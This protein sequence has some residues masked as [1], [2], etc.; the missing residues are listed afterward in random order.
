MSCRTTCPTLRTK[1]GS[2][3][4][5]KNLRQEAEKREGGAGGKREGSG[6]KS[7]RGV[8]SY[9]AAA[10]VAAV[11]IG[12]RGTFTR[13]A[14][15]ASQCALIGELKAGWGAMQREVQQ[16]AA[17]EITKESKA[18]LVR[19]L[20][21]ANA[22]IAVLESEAAAAHPASRPTPNPVTASNPRLRGPTPT[23]APTPAPEPKQRKYNSYVT[24]MR[25]VKKLR[26]FLGLY[27]PEAHAD[28]VARAIVVDGRGKKS[29]ISV[30][31]VRDLFAN[32]RMAVHMKA[33]AEDILTRAK[34]HMQTA[35]FSAANFTSARRLCRLSYRKLGWLRR[36]LSHNGKTSRL[37]LPPYS[38]CVPMMPSVPAMKY[39]EQSMLDAHGGIVQQEDGRGA[40]CEDLERVLCSAI[41]YAHTR[42]V[43]ASDGSEADPHIFMWGGDGFMARKKSKWVQ[44]GVILCSTTSLNQSPVDSKFVLNYA[45]GEDYDVLSIRTEDLRPVL[46]R[47]AREGKVWD[48]Y[49]KLPSGIGAHVQ[50]AL[51]GDKP[52]ILT[53]LGRRNMNHTHFSA[54]C[55]CTRE[56]ISCLDCE[57]GQE[58]HYVTDPDEMCRASH[59]CP[60]MWLRGG[61]FVPFKCPCCPAEFTCVSDVEAEEARV[62]VMDACTFHRWAD[63]FSHAHWGRDWNAGVLLPFKWIWSDPLHLFLNL[64]NVAFDEGVDFFLQHEH[65][66][67][68]SKELIAECHTISVA[69]NRELAGAHIT[70]RFGTDERKSFCGNDLRALMQHPYVLPEIM[71]LVRPLYLRMEPCSFAAD[72][73]KARK[74]KKRIEE[75]LEKEQE[76]GIKGGGGRAR[77]V[78]ADSFNETA[79]ISA[80]AARRVRKTQAALQVATEKTLTF[81]DRF[82]SHIDAMS[83]AIDGNYNWCVI[84]ML[85]ALVEFYEWVHAKSWLADALAADAEL[86]GGEG[87]R[88]GR[89]PSVTET[90]KRRRTECMERS[91]ALAK[92]IIAAVGVARKQTYV[93]D[94]VY[95]LHRVFD[96]VLHLLLAGMQGVEHVNKQMKL[97]LVSQCTAANNNRKTA[98]GKQMLGDVAQAA[99]C[100]VARQHIVE[101]R[102]DSLP[103]SQYGQRLMGHLGWGSNESIARVAKRD[104]KVFQAGSVSGLKELAAG[105]YSPQPTAAAVSPVGMAALLSDPPRQRWKRHTPPGPSCLRPDFYEP[106]PGCARK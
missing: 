34:E 61:E 72:A 60:N 89:G 23:P 106:E 59:V 78:D 99:L 77:R 76:A 87:G 28:L 1:G 64:F 62:L 2:Y 5:K 15:N 10:D 66:S 16:K 14:E 54:T 46:Q 43:L 81:E 25:A 73:A 97:A 20:A 58:S 49:G 91:M 27:P 32:P 50:F 92:D 82:S 63:T 103:Q 7:K 53:V 39:D 74:E 71:S 52:W 35:V 51:G 11:R 83:Q 40:V 101:L 8:D 105:V 44:L 55:K 57:G 69:V 68:E 21:E 67:A 75:R 88:R 37:M 98:S 96:A 84:N 102:G 17:K 30:S 70:A 13:S 12:V 42:G 36:L 104:H 56:N 94:L 38:T 85:N 45:G 86:A 9:S 79:G 22:R 93:H 33:Y 18:C 48:G 47:V 90:V 65:V 80:E 19:K 95:G 100:K 26:M 4:R 24:R 31:L 41:E 3:Q 29:G 6:Q